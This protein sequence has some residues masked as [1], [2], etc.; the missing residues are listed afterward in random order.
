MDDIAK[1]AA[2]GEDIPAEKLGQQLQLMHGQL[3]GLRLEEVVGQQLDTSHTTALLAE[4]DTLK[5]GRD[6]KQKAEPSPASFSLYI[7]PGQEEQ[8]AA[9][10]SSLAARLARLETAL[11]TTPEA[12][13]VLSTETG[14]KNLAG[15][16]QVLSAKTALLDPRKLDHIEGRLGALQQKLSARHEGAGQGAGQERAGGRLQEM[17]ATVERNKA[18]FAS[19]AG[20]LA[21]LESLQGLHQ[22]AAQFSTDLTQLDCLGSQLLVQLNNDLSLLNNTKQMFDKNITNIEQNFS[23]L[24]QRIDKLSQ[25]KQKKK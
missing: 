4:L 16:V 11:G 15:A 8:D 13:A 12:M 23:S 17:A 25:A 7:D 19:L 9:E 10:L 6:G 22:Q 14:K 24:F 18:G 3:V 5:A 20:L 2:E 21:R 1:S